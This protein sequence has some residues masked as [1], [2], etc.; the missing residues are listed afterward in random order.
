MG[1]LTDDEQGL[2]WTLRWALGAL[3][4]VWVAAG[5]LFAVN[6]VSRAVARWEVSG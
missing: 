4:V 2:L 6:Q 1:E 3:A 5:G